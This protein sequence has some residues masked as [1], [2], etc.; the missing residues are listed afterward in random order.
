MKTTVRAAD[1]ILEETLRQYFGY[2]TFRAQQKDIITQVLEGKD[3]VVLMPTGGGKSL[4]Y[5]LPAVLLEGLTVVISPLIALMK[6]QVQALQGN[7]IAA[8]CLNSS[9]TD[10]EER[11]VRED[12]Q[13]GN[14]KLLYVSP[15]RLLSPHF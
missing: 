9:L 13:A 12:L 15:E 7:G 10:A 4:C 11:Q 14:V 6:D 1:P 8:A 5:Q 3:A 2:D